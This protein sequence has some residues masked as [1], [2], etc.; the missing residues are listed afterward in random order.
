MR[1]LK[2]RTPDEIAADSAEARAH[3]ARAAGNHAAADELMQTAQRLR[4]VASDDGLSR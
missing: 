1:P 3:D 2:A 4:G